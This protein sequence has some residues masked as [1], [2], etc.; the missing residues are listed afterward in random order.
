MN[1]VPAFMC[2]WCCAGVGGTLIN[3]L[4]AA[5]SKPLRYPPPPNTLI[6]VDHDHQSSGIIPASHQNQP[7]ILPSG[8]AG[9]GNIG[10]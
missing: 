5:V 7:G 9:L 10:F 3:L 6:H 8:N 2:C 4:A 1:G